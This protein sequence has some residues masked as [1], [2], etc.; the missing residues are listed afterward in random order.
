MCIS[1]DVSPAAPLFLVLSATVRRTRMRASRAGSMV[2]QF[3]LRQPSGFRVWV[4]RTLIFSSV[5]VAI[6]RHASFRPVSHS[7]SAFAYSMLSAVCVH[8]LLGPASYTFTT[9]LSINPSF[10]SFPAWTSPLTP[11]LASI[12]ICRLISWTQ[13]SS[14]P[15]FKLRMQQSV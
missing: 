7:P 11:A 8:A 13:G 1:R 5:A 3:A 15:R 9:S 2:K 12:S 4:R 10:L 6:R 14:K